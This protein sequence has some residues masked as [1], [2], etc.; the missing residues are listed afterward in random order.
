MQNDREIEE[1][2]AQRT[3]SHW[4]LGGVSCVRVARD[5]ED[6]GRKEATGLAALPPS[7]SLF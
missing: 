2:G 3:L 7:F 6:L 5:G 4:F 1:T